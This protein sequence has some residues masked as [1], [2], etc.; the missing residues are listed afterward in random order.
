M[1]KGITIAAIIV[2]ILAAIGYVVWPR[3]DELSLSPR[4]HT[5]EEICEYAHGIDNTATVSEE[6]TDETIDGHVYRTWPA[7]IY[8]TDCKI[9]SVPE[10]RVTTSVLPILTGA[11]RK[12][13][14]RLDT[15]YDYILVGKALEDHPE[16]GELISSEFGRTVIS[17]VTM[18][19]ISEEELAKLNTT[20]N[21]IVRSIPHNTKSYTAQVLAGDHEINFMPGL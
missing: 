1:K 13:F 3:Y 7:K 10:E 16:F 17:R 19:E 8:G 6:F 12:D 15:N 2:I 20:Y 18:D 9:A 14:Y 11:F 21:E 4:M 5:Y